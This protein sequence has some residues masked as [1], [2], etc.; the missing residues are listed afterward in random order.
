[1]FPIKGLYVKIL[2][3]LIKKKIAMFLKRQEYLNAIEL[4]LVFDRSCELNTIIIC[5]IAVIV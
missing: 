4:I 1:M 2:Y 5:A 3:H